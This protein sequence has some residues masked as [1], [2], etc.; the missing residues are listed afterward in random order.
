ACC[1]VANLVHGG[2]VRLGLNVGFRL[3]QWRPVPNGL[4]RT[5]YVVEEVQGN[6][7]PLDTGD[8]LTAVVDHL[9]ALE[10]ATRNFDPPTAKPPW[11]ESCNRQ[12]YRKRLQR[13]LKGL[14]ERDEITFGERDEV[15]KRFDEYWDVDPL[16]AGRCLSHGDFSQGNVRAYGGDFWLI[17]FEHA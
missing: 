2:L 10:L 17:D 7:P 11:I 14:H 5:V 1:R 15:V 12:Q 13:S 16:D 9:V 8:E 6:A 3:P 4:E